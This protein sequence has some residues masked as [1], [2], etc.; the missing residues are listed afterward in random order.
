MRLA[1]L[2]IFACLPAF[3]TDRNAATCA[4]ADVDTAYAAAVDGD[5]VLLPTCTAT[6][7][8]SAL[9]IS[10]AIQFLGN[11]EANTIL[12]NAQFNITVGDGKTWR[13]SGFSTSGTTGFNVTG[14]SKAGRMDHITFTGG[15]TGFT[16]NRVFWLSPD[17][18]GFNAGLID[19]ITFTPGDNVLNS[20]Q[21]HHREGDGGNASWTRPL[22]LGGPDAWYVEDSS[23]RQTP[24]NTCAP[25]GTSPCYNISAPMTDCD[26]GGRFVFRY[27]TINTNY[28]EMHDAIVDGIR[29]CRKWEIYNNTWTTNSSDYTAS[30]QYAQL[31]I[32][33]G[34]GVVYNN[35]FTYAGFTPYLII[36]AAYRTA[37]S[38]GVP[39]GFCPQKWC[40]ISGA[41]CL[42][43]TE[44]NPTGTNGTCTT[45]TPNKVCTQPGAGVTAC[46]SDA[47]CGGVSGACQLTDGNGRGTGL[48]GYPCRDQMGTDGV[49]SGEQQFRPALFW[50]NK[51]GSTQY[52]AG[53]SGTGDS[54]YLAANRDYCNGTG[55]GSGQ[56]TTCGGRAVPYTPYTYPHPLQSGFQAPKKATGVN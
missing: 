37:Q 32:R 6:T 52:D 31:A 35:T 27:N 1:W 36:F 16:A 47:N 51:V 24:T 7:W 56:P 54:T 50:N 48:S 13:V 20:I 23:F 45:T 2:L 29:G 49:I 18:G 34:T 26:G 9:T 21:V 43:N 46:S 28:F 22:N 11:G 10:K 40:S 8:G 53:Y 15:V 3:A 41:A 17:S 38:G 4:K 25:G 19:H 12:V 55:G 14:W 33:G 5:R 39:W 44:C 30:G 42:T